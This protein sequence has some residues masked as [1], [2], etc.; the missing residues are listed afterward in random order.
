[1]VAVAACGGDDA[2]SP[3]QVTFGETTFVIIVNPPINQVNQAS[4]PSPGTARLNVTASVQGG[5]SGVTDQ[6]GVVVLRPITGGTR[7]LSFSGGGASGQLSVSIAEKDL[8]EVAVASGSSGS[9]EMANVQYAFGGQVVEVR[10]S[11]TIQ[12]VNAELAKSN[13]IVFF[14]SG[15]YTGDLTFAGSNVTLFGEGPKGGT[16]TL[17][18]KVTVSGS[19][20]RMRGVRVT[21][22]MT[23]PG[24]DF[25]ISFSRVAGA[26]QMA[27]SNGALLNNAFCSSVTISGSGVRALGNTG[28][29]P[30][31]APSGG[32]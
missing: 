22:T 10:P 7:S 13:L 8:R 21:G 31:P 9:S 16:V 6:D 3:T 12:Q 30:L 17:S 14:R 27:G 1:M 18:G 28:L 5:P 4:V 20:N 19:R 29:A 23:V 2:T 26:F 25:G 11:M 32:C 24:S 15:T